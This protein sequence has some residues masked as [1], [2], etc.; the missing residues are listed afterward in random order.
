MRNRAYFYINR[1]ATSL[2]DK[3]RNKKAKY[4]KANRA[5]L[6]SF[7]A[8]LLSRKEINIVFNIGY[9]LYKKEIDVNKDRNIIN[10]ML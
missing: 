4:L 9:N 10:N 8:I 1:D 3:A 5:L 2:K 6:P 7:N